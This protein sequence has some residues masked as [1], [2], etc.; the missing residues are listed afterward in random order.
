M[1]DDKRI[2]NNIYCKCLFIVNHD[3]FRK[4]IY[5]ELSRVVQKGFHGV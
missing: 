2:Y 3:I 1:Q 4:T 5:N